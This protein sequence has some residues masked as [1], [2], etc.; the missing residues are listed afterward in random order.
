MTVVL[1][2]DRQRD[3]WRV[4]MTWSRRTPRYFGTF[5]SQAEAEKWIKEHHWLANRREPPD[6]KN[7]RHRRPRK[8]LADK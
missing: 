7:R 3:R 1:T 5:N 6:E 4:K 8:R 2:S